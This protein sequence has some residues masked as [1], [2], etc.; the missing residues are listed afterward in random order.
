[1]PTHGTPV[2]ELGWF[3]SWKPVEPDNSG[4][5][6]VQLFLIG[7]YA[8]I[9]LICKTILIMLFAIHAGLR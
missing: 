8:W 5:A 2:L 6:R 9:R 7:V 4:R 1:M 3:R